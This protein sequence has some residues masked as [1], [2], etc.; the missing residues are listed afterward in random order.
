MNSFGGV[1]KVHNGY[2]RRNSNQSKFGGVLK[3]RY[4]DPRL[5]NSQRS[6]EGNFECFKCSQRGHYAISCPLSYEQ[7]KERKTD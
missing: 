5:Y 2:D 1:S 3:R 4:N 6:S 7:K